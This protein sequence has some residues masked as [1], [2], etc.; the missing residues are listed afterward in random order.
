[1]TRPPTGEFGPGG[2][3]KSTPRGQV[4][5]VLGGQLAVTSELERIPIAGSGGGLAIRVHFSSLRS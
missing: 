4:L 2:P 5:P 1:M 3:W